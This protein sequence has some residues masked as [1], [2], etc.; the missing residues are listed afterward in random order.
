MQF[1]SSSAILFLFCCGFCFCDSIADFTSNLRSLAASSKCNLAWPPWRM[2]T[3]RNC[4]WQL[5]SPSGKRTLTL[6][7][8]GVSAGKMLDVLTP[9][10][11][12]DLLSIDWSAST[13]C[14]FSISS[15]Y[16]VRRNT[17]VTRECMTLEAVQT[18]YASF[19]AI[20]SFHS[21][22]ITLFDCPHI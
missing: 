21:G 6:R 14:S 13:R 5:H 9:L 1:S 7:F 16:V 17:V 3:D 19:V 15:S 11:C 22:G 18:L 10:R 12:L 2:A 4:K 20:S 8:R